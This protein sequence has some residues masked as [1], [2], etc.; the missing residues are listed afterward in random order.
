MMADRAYFCFLLE[1][2]EMF[3][4]LTDEESGKMI[5]AMIAYEKE[6][7]EPDFVEKGI[8]QFAWL[9]NVK[10][11]MDVLKEHYDSKRRQTSEAGKASA[12]KRKQN[13]QNQQTLTHVESVEQNKQ[14][15]IDVE[16]FMESGEENGTPKKYQP[17]IDAWNEL[18][19]PNVVAIH[20]KRLEALRAR[21]KEYSLDD[22]IS[23]IRGIKDCPFLLG[24]NQRNWQITIDWFVKPNNF[25]KVLEGNYRSVSAGDTDFTAVSKRVREETEERRTQGKSMS[26]DDIKKMVEERRKNAEGT[27]T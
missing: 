18:P 1:W 2:A 16:C 22:I 19:L 23:A 26:M 14:E 17:I 5:K 15:L 3:S 6:K 20:G 4:L 11:K 25:P 7:T 12:E 10:P 27:V 9:S 13:K 21:E 8:L 24:Q